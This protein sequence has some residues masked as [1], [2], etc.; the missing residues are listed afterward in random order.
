MDWFSLDQVMLPNILNYEAV[1]QASWMGRKDSLSG[2][3]FFQVVQC[4]DVRSQLIEKPHKLAFLGFCCDE[5]IKRNEGRLGAKTGPNKIREQLG[6]L[7]CHTKQQYL[8]LGN[9]VCSDGQLENSQH[10]FAK[11]VNYCHQK[12]L[13]T[14]AFGGGH[15]IAWAH[16]SGLT[17]HYPKLGII[18][19]DAHFDIRPLIDEKYGS[20]GTPFAQ[21]KTYCQQKKLD[22]DYCCLGIQPIANTQ[23]LFER[24]H[25]WRVPYLTAEQ[26]NT[27]N[28]SW[29]IDFLD[30]FMQKHDHIY[31]SICLDVFAA[32]YAPG[33][34]APQSLG[35]NPWQ[36]LPL[37]KYITQTGKV[38][39][40]DIAE[41]SP[42]LDPE[43][44]TSRLAAGIMAELLNARND[45]NE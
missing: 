45:S 29:Q 33:V 13:K 21:I 11:L 26:I 16:F 8:D 30:E 2:E 12:G 43:Q 9:I 34:S 23:S 40:I 18:N 5:G 15:E 19:F 24:A 4:Q 36:V 25:E 41:L 22:F 1:L 17:P 28:L 32:C 14:V 39:G 35:L 31:L 44:H 6:K 20:S 27:E 42:P 38:V 3:R 37:L 7:A 10:E